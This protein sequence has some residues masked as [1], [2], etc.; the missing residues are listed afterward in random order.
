MH[1]VS[2]CPAVKP[3]RL[4]VV[5]TGLSHR[6]LDSDESDLGRMNHRQIHRRRT[7]HQGP[8]S[9]PGAQ[10]AI[11]VA[12]NADP[13]HQSLLVEDQRVDVALD[14][15]RRESLGDPPRRRR[16]CS[17]RHPA[18]SRRSCSGTRRLTE[19]EHA[20]QRQHP[21]HA[22]A[23]RAQD[24]RQDADGEEPA[25]VPPE[26][27]EDR[28]PTDSTEATATESAATEAAA[29]PR[30]TASETA[31]A[32]PEAVATTA[33][34]ST[35]PAA[36]ATIPAAATEQTAAAAAIE[37]AAPATRAPRAAGRALIARPP[38]VLLGV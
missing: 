34:A 24:D 20:G 23:D 4:G 3:F 11:Q 26:L 21:R 31:A 32:T 22:E 10:R 9:L 7:G 18:P 30:S 37:A 14:R 17:G 13:R 5:R 36:A 6:G 16:R 19:V 28:L 15:A 25:P 29:A 38:P 2:P 33:P 12:M 1:A 27:A 8:G 35:V